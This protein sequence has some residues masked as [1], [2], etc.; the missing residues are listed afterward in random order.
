MR[1]IVVSDHY[2]GQVADLLTQI[3]PGCCAALHC[4]ATG[5][6]ACA[7]YAACVW[8]HPRKLRHSTAVHRHSGS[9]R[10]HLRC[11]IQGDSAASGGADAAARQT[12]GGSSQQQLAGRSRPWWVLAVPGGCSSVLC[13]RAAR[14]RFRT[15]PHSTA[16]LAT[17]TPVVE[18]APVTAA[19]GRLNRLWWCSCGCQADL[20]QQQQQQWVGQRVGTSRQ[21]WVSAGAGGCSNPCAL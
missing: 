14:L 5:A 11:Q 9:Q 19:T 20:Q 13:L 12:H 18:A 21:W 6:G 3:L 10:Q 1:N 4:I 17:I 16:Q 8:P 2:C 7:P 15:I